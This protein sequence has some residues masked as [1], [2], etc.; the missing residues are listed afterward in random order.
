MRCGTL[1]QVTA[2]LCGECL[3]LE[4]SPSVDFKKDK[5]CFGVPLWSSACTVTDLKKQRR[6]DL[7]PDFEA[8]HA[9]T[10]EVSRLARL[11][12]WNIGTQ[13]EV[14]RLRVAL[15]CR[16]L[17]L[18]EERRKIRKKIG[19]RSLISYY[20]IDVHLGADYLYG[21]KSEWI[22]EQEDEELEI[23]RFSCVRLG[24]EGLFTGVNDYFLPYPL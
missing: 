22:V 20:M 14:E 5:K 6:P 23:C 17:F 24:E 10:I 4:G 2:L 21:R 9:R 3:N 11:A 1:S 8:L 7:V 15:K 16:G 18:V 12:A 19:E 13:R